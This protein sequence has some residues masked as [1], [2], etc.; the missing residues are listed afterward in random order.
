MIRPFA[1]IALLA[2]AAPAAAQTP[3]VVQAPAAQATTPAAQAP[4][5]PAGSAPVLKALEL[6]F[7]P[8]TGSMVEPMT[9]A[10]YLRSKVSQP[11][12]TGRWETYDEASILA[13]FRRVML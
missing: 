9:Y 5:P 13:D 7:H 3:P 12:T 2:C 1:M 10:F 11:R 8:D 4:Q 6:R